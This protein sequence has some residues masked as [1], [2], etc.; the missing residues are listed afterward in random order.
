MDLLDT[1]IQNVIK[2]IPSVISVAKQD[3]FKSRT[4]A[5]W[6]LIGSAI[7]IA[8]GYLI[9]VKRIKYSI[10]LQYYLMCFGKLIEK[11]FLQSGDKLEILKTSELTV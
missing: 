9:Q 1:E 11:G 3:I 6:A 8:T 5:N 4:D 10:L 7:G 2:G